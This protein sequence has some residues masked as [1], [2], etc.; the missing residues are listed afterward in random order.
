V[1]LEAGRRERTR[2][3]RAARGVAQWAGGDGIFSVRSSVASRLRL[4]HRFF[5]KRMAGTG[6]WVPDLDVSVWPSEGGAVHF[7]PAGIDHL[8]FRENC[9]SSEE[10]LCAPRVLLLC[11]PGYC[12][13]GGIS[14][15]RHRGGWGSAR[16]SVGWW[17]GGVV[18]RR[19]RRAGG[20]WGWRGWSGEQKRMSST[21]T[22]R[23]EEGRAQWCSCARKVERGPRNHPNAY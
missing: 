16:I 13:L 21:A 17:C 5:C 23:E 7:F 18:R 4:V 14:H 8:T 9:T 10:L 19:G 11:A 12:G 22:T 6:T 1:K 3:R 2:E 15:C 20:G